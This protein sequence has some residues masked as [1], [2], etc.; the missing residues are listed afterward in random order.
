MAVDF[1]LFVLFSDAHM[2]IS[3]VS[4]SS[5]YRKWTYSLCIDCKRLLPLL[6]DCFADGVNG[7]WYL[8]LKIEYAL[9]G[10]TFIC[11]WPVSI[12][13][14]KR[15]LNWVCLVFSIWFYSDCLSLKWWSLENCLNSYWFNKLQI[16]QLI[17][18]A[19]DSNFTF[20]YWN[21]MHLKGNIILINIQSA[22]VWMNWYKATC[23]LFQLHIIFEIKYKERCFKLKLLAFRFNINEI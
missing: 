19:M 20:R 16:T 2:V 12:L 9:N 3:F 8:S 1:F 5:S 11:C 18:N 10:V 13:D 6:F 21:I 7:V 17:L 23:F 4:I 14:N 22:I 15:R